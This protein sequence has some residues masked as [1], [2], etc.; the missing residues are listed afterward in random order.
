MKD[1]QEIIQFATGFVVIVGA[2]VTALWIGSALFN[3][4]GGGSL[5]AVAVVND[6]QNVTHSSSTIVATSTNATLVLTADGRRQYAK[7]TNTD[8][9]IAYCVL[10][11]TS[12]LAT[13]GDVQGILLTASGG[14]YTIDN[15]N[16]WK[17]AVSCYS[18]GISIFSIITSP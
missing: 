2:I 3:G 15:S 11:A 10:G 1:K 12:T 7:I 17:G 13:G 16:S 6:I 8:A 5:G 9:N 18:P 4:A 14:S